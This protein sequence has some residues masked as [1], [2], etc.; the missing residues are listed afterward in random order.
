MA[1]A[2]ITEV[3]ISSGVHYVEWLDAGDSAS[4]PSAYSD[5]SNYPDLASRGMVPWFLHHAGV[6]QSAVPLVGD[7]YGAVYFNPDTGARYAVG[8]VAPGGLPDFVETAIDLAGI[9][10]ALPDFSDGVH[11]PQLF[12]AAGYVGY[13]E[14]EPV[15]RGRFWT[16]LVRCTEIV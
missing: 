8:T 14:P 9:I 4:V 1:L 7:G 2:E 10:A 15:E 3:P 12:I 13:G 16:G 5:G 11:E 6:L